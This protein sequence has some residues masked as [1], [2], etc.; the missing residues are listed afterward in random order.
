MWRAEV[1][2]QVAS[3]QDALKLLSHRV[4]LHCH[5]KGVEHN[6]DGD[7]QINKRVHDNQVDDVLKL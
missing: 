2:H 7:G 1:S 3:R 6:A 4:V 5:E